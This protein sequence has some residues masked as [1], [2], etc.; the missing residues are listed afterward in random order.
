MEIA[1]ITF[2]PKTKRLKKLDLLRKDLKFKCQRCAVFCCKLGGPT[3]NVKDVQRLRQA[4]TK[5]ENYGKSKKD[6]VRICLKETENGSCVFLEYDDES[7][8]HACSIYGF[9]PT[10]CRLY[11]FEFTLTSPNTGV[12]KIIPCCNG[13]N[14]ADGELVDQKFVEKNLLEPIIDSLKAE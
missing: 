6:N 11:P 14:A 1:E 10:F 13:L 5:E 7:K 8:Q 4:G 3:L 9:R 2:N 12:L